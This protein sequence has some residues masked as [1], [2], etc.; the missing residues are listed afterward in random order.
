VPHG[1]PLIGTYEVI[2]RASDG[3]GHMTPTESHMIDV[4]QAAVIDGN[5]CFGGTMGADRMTIYP[6]NT[7]GEY[8]CRL[9]ATTMGPFVPDPEC[10]MFVFACAGNDIVTVSGSIAG[11]CQL[12]GGEGDDYLAGGAG[13]DI[14]VGGPGNDRLLGGE[15]DNV[16]YGGE[17]DDRIYGRSGNDMLLGG[18]GNDQL[19]G[20]G[21]DDVLDGEEG[22][23]FLD[24]GFGNDI[25]RGGPGNDTLSGYYGDDFLL[26]GT[27]D[28]QLLG[29]AGND[30]LI[31]GEGADRLRGD[32]GND[33]LIAGTTANDSDT[34]AA[35]MA[36]LASWSG[37]GVNNLSGFVADGDADLLIGD[38]GLDQ[39]WA[40]ILPPTALDRVYDQSA[41]EV[42]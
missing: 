6:M 14:L 35:L 38:L 22:D 37:S 27:G 33:L 5:L 32:V 9:D 24:G 7:P 36:L 29:R 39:F 21:G 10:T 34:D 28:D 18:P 4:E 15:G 20:S 16:I 41:M 12:D 30:I 26:G 23:D 42:V 31:G 2:V 8:A 11:C 19:S 1:Y 40:D 25:L 17:G 13:N 3:E